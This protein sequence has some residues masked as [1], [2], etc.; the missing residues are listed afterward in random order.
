MSQKRS[1]LAAAFR[2]ASGDPVSRFDA[3]EFHEDHPRMA[4]TVFDKSGKVVASTG[5]VASDE[6]GFRIEGATAY[7]G[8]TLV[9][10][11]LVLSTNWADTEQGLQRLELVLWSIW[12]PLSFLVGA[13]TWLA[14]LSVFRPLQRLSDQA[15]EISGSS[16][17]ERLAT[18]DRAE[19]G[20][21]AEHLNGM[22]D[23]IRQSV[24]RE[25]KFAVDA[26]HELRT[27]LAI[28]RTRVETT[29]LRER[30]SEEYIASHKALLG[31]IDRLTRIALSLL[32]STR[33]AD[34]VT[35]ST[36][37]SSVVGEAVSGWTD[38][39]AEHR[40]ELRHTLDVAYASI[41]PAEVRIV[42][43]NLLDNALRFSDPDSQVDV[44]L[45]VTPD[46][47]SLLTVEDEGPGIETSLHEAVFERLFRVDNH[48]NRSN[49]GSGIGLAVSRRIVEARGGA[50]ACENRDPRGARFVCR[51][52]RAEVEA[53][54]T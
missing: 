41:E 44:K 48:R 30:S 27:P 1:E 28:M 32:Q 51:L 26:A 33:A 10:G 20:A 16:R 13:S 21:F 22:L 9:G 14:A 46:G 52:P 24:H 31:E 2:S 5:P 8:G 54:R 18:T 50:L 34:P 43:D 40:V 42:L 38:R 12:L 7:Y 15:A 53:T 37:L 17:D 25:E 47:G 35:E 39:F 19:F 11:R 4:A 49:G 29:L 45:R 23:R 6:L 36:E 3:S